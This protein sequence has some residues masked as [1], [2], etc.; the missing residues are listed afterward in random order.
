MY[1]H[2]YVHTY[3]WD[4]LHIELHCT[5]SKVHQIVTSQ[6]PYTTSCFDHS[7]PGMI[8]TIGAYACKHHW[9]YV[10]LLAIVVLLLKPKAD[11]KSVNLW[12]F[13]IVCERTSIMSELPS[14][15]GLFKRMHV[16]IQQ[17]PHHN[18]YCTYCRP[19]TPTHTCMHV[20]TLY[21]HTYIHT[22]KRLPKHKAT[23]VT[24]IP[25]SAV[26][27]P[28]ASSWPWASAHWRRQW[29]HRSVWRYKGITQR[30]PHTYIHTIC[31]S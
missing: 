23:H 20:H 30:P 11:E 7:L 29:P 24:Y 19:L 5:Q 22:H 27:P 16:C 26:W 9:G 3:A 18:T 25:S 10:P 6:V 12:V 28:L 8:N 4:E 17:K 14:H 2:T 21:I 13:W 15:S 31:A 1:I